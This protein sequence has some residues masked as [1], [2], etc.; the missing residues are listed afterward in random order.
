MAYLTRTVEYIDQRVYLQLT[1]NFKIIFLNTHANDW[2]WFVFQ[3]IM[4]ENE[5]NLP[6]LWDALN[7][8]LICIPEYIKE[9]SECF[10]LSDDVL[11]IPNAIEEFKRSEEYQNLKPV[12]WKNS[13]AYNYTKLLEL[14][15]TVLVSHDYRP[16]SFT[17]DGFSEWVLPETDFQTQEEAQK[18]A[19]QKLREYAIMILEQTEGLQ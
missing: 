5:D 1:P 15:K 11:S 13:N 10:E 6:S 7:D 16:R 12:E 9:E 18:Y 19:V 4:V 17:C 2:G 8:A 14:S 3:P